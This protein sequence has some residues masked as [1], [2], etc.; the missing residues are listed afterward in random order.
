MDELPV[1]VEGTCHYQAGEIGVSHR[2]EGYSLAEE[3]MK[4][5]FCQVQ[6]ACCQKRL[7]ECLSVFKHLPVSVWA[8]EEIYRVLVFPHPELEQGE[9]PITFVLPLFVVRSNLLRKLLEHFHDGRA[10]STHYLFKLGVHRRNIYLL[11][12]TH[13]S[14]SFST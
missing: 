3:P 5:V 2:V 8:P 10:M 4:W 9:P 7:G 6:S 1:H 13:L 11:S 14:M 12:I